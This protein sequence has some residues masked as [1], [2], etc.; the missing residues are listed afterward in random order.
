MFS[1]TRGELPPALRPVGRAWR[2]SRC[3][4]RRSAL[5]NPSLL[6][7]SALPRPH[8]SRRRGRA[9]LRT[10]QPRRGPPRVDTAEPSRDTIA[11][12]ARFPGTSEPISASRPSARA[13]PSVAELERL[14]GGQD[15]RPRPRGPAPKRRRSAAPRRSRTTARRP[16]CP[17]RHRRAA[18]ASAS[19]ASGATPQPSAPFERGQCATPVPV[20]ASRPISSSSSTTQCAAT[21]FGPRRSC[22]ASRCVPVLPGGGTSSSLYA[23][24]APAPVSRYADLDRLSRD[25]RRDGQPEL[26]A[27]FVELDRDRVGSV[28]RDAGRAPAREN[29]VADTIAQPGEVLERL[30]RIAAEDLEVDGCAQTRAPRRPPRS[31]RCSCSRRPSSRPRRGTARHRT[32]QRRRTP[33]QPIRALRWMCSVIHSAKSPSPSPK[34]PYTAYS[35]CECAFTNPGTITASS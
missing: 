35:R 5:A 9:T 8:T 7:R 13:E 15:V 4:R 22:S 14:A 30:R 21:T 3:A 23:P 6:S 29:A 27:G 24:H 32:S 28:R 25:V 2:A 12:S 11:K 34:P 16:G 19:S 17:C 10:R 1:A 31:R 20:A 33:S 26:S 18:P